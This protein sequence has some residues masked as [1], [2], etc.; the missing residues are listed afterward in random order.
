V[1]YLTGAREHW[2]SYDAYRH[3]LRLALDTDAPLW[4]ILRLEA[5]HLNKAQWL[6]VSVRSLRRAG[7]QDVRVTGAGEVINAWVWPESAM[8]VVY[9]PELSLDESSAPLLPVDDDRD[10]VKPSDLQTEEVSLRESGSQS[11]AIGG[12]P[13]ILSDPMVALDVLR[14]RGDVKIPHL[15][16]YSVLRIGDN[17]I[18][19]NQ[20]LGLLQY[21][22]RVFLI[23]SKPPTDSEREQ[24]LP[25]IA[26]RLLEWTF[27]NVNGAQGFCAVDGIADGK[28]IIE[29][30]NEVVRVLH[31]ADDNG[32]FNV[33]QYE[34]VHADHTRDV[35][36]TAG[37]GTGKTE[38]MSERIVY[39][40]ATSALVE[41]RET[42]LYP[43]DLKMNDIV[44]VTFTREAA[45]QMRERI[46]RVLNLRR[47]LCP[48]CV[49]AAVSWMF[50]LT[51]T[52][53]STIHMYAQHVAQQSAAAIGFNPGLSVG[54]QLIELRR[55]MYEALSTRLVR[56]LSGPN[57]GSSDQH[58]ASH[59]W[60]NHMERI[61]ESLANN[62]VPI[63]PLGEGKIPDIDWGL[64]ENLD[65]TTHEYAEMLKESIETA[66]REFAKLC[67]ENDL[68]PVDQL[69]PAAL[70]GLLSAAN[71]RIG[72]PRFL[73]VDEFQDTD[74][75]Q[76]DL[77]LEIS[78]R[79]DARMFVVG[80]VKQGIYRFRGAEGSA[81]T[82]LARRM[83]VAGLPP[84]LELRLNRN[85]RTGGVLLGDMGSYFREWGVTPAD[86][87]SD[88]PLLDYG[89]K[90][91]LK[92]EVDRKRQGSRVKL[93]HASYDNYL[94]KLV[95]QI[96]AWRTIA[97]ADPKHV[98]KIGILCRQNW[99]ANKI[100]DELRREG[101]PCDVLVGG[102]FYQSEAVREVRV[103]FD[104]IMSPDDTAAVLEFCETRW[105]GG[106]SSSQEPPDGLENDV[107]WRDEVAPIMSWSDRL[108]FLHPDAGENLKV[109]DLEPI[110]ARLRSLSKLIQVMSPVALLAQCYHKFKPHSWLRSESD[111]E[112]LV[113]LPAYSRCLEHLLVLLDLETATRPLTLPTLV[114][115]LRIQIA[116]NDKE[117]EPQPKVLGITTA[118]TVH[119]AKGQEFDFVIIPHTW[120]Q[121]ESSE[122]SSLVSVVRRAQ[123]G[124]P[125]VMWRWRLDSGEIANFDTS[126]PAAQGEEGE[127]R[128]EETRLLYVAMTRARDE[129]FIYWQKQPKPGSWGELLAIGRSNT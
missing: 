50:Q 2:I 111:P 66:G 112:R 52:Q 45:T 90:D 102:T 13:R 82:E 37:A 74:G 92:A 20:L 36:I 1:N 9:G 122:A 28:K 32:G 25:F 117:D 94:T 33:G 22:I 83:Q 62:G 121:F 40:L 5:S 91:E 78:Q 115:W 72:S 113:D 46:A 84:A 76:M 51:S 61:W 26:S 16:R 23:T 47:R 4:I 39:L 81:F 57:S 27:A 24:Y 69:V 18:D 80:D 12:K 21:G 128:R 31:E 125:K 64:N 30:P 100:R 110:R 63:L 59:E 54:S 8:T 38:T 96:K 104:A 99:V 11:E 120:A 108:P 116:T 86:I 44:L 14:R 89:E 65:S 41:E 10:A 55:I 124:Q 6:Q 73:F 3:Y 123:T 75:K 87:H 42:K 29:W 77:I 114:D 79:L 85:F 93:Q 129:L 19:R 127:T 88:R 43:Y 17:D 48:K 103:L 95:A 105:F 68:L 118:L 106:F 70:Q 35:V 107:S 7:R 56:L 34:I 71:P 109:N 126:S 49:L 58:P 98:K 97:E 101:E 119:K 53:I 15:P 60:L 67:E